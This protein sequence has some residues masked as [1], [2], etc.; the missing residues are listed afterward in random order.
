MA[1]DNGVPF[2]KVQG[3]LDDLQRSLTVAH[4]KDAMPTTAPTQSGSTQ[5]GSSSG[6][7]TQSND[8]K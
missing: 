6:S 1:D 3:S 2:N 8:K 4:T 7:Q 5:T